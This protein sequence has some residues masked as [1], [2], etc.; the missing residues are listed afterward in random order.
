MGS[1]VLRKRF[2]LVHHI[3]VFSPAG[4]DGPSPSQPDHD[5]PSP[6]NPYSSLLWY[7][8]VSSEQGQCRIRVAGRGAGAEA[9]IGA[10]TSLSWSRVAPGHV[11][12][13][14]VQHKYHPKLISIPLN[15]HCTSL[16]LETFTRK[17]SVQRLLRYLSDKKQNPTTSL[18]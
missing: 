11:L 5:A 6:T 16:D 2:S 10:V 18:V 13:S 4:N 14:G 9:G 1:Y 8:P 17:Y 3:L 7:R 15:S 12:K